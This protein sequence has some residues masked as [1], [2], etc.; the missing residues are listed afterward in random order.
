MK[1]IGGY[2]LSVALVFLLSY[3]ILLN[4]SSRKIVIEYP[5]NKTLF[6]PEFP[7]P[8]FFWKHKGTYLGEWRVRLLVNDSVVTDT[9]VREEKWRPESR[10]WE[11]IKRIAKNEHIVFQLS[12]PK[13]L[14]K[15][16]LTFSFSNDSVG[17]PILFRQLPIPFVLAEKILDSMNYVLVD[18]GYDGPPHVAMKSFPVCGNC[19][20]F[21]AGG[22][23]IGLDL[24]AGL[25]D[26]G[27]YFIAPITDTIVFDK[28]NYHSWTKIEQRRTFGMF[29]KLSPDGRYIVTTVK[30]R[31]ISKNFPFEPQHMAF[32]QLF[33]P[34][35]G[36]LAVYDRQTKVL[37]ELPGANLPEYVQSN[38]TWTP[39]GKYIV[40]CRAKALPYDNN[41]TL[42]INITDEALMEEFVQRK[43]KVKFDI[44]IIP[45]NDGKGGVAQPIKGASEN[46]KSNYF[47]A[48]SPDGKWLVFCQA[49]SFMLLQPDSR[50]YIVPLEGGKARPLECNLKLMNSWHAWSP[51]GKWLT[52]VS[53]GLSIYTD[54][55]LT[56]IDE[57]G[58]ASPPVLVERARK[59][60]RVV[61]YP[62]F[63]N[64]PASKKFDMIY[65]YVELV[66]IQK[67]LLDN[68]I[69]KARQLYFK[70][71]QQ[72]H[73]FMLNEDVEMLKKLL[74]Q[75]HLPQEKLWAET[76]KKK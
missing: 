53:K 62:E 42:Q 43:R 15:K 46:G 22:E 44:C 49:E 48:V 65:D 33:F 47:P 40:F 67:A 38:A 73:S 41:D 34:V 69:T 2:I 39:D 16:S 1:K 45:F 6:P 72:D 13:S 31:V 57:K 35:N 51:N 19:H 52:F 30:D 4:F 50:L 32:S 37:K 25:R 11:N 59:F 61:N 5:F 76:L 54:L 56:H 58:H 18:V 12:K 36:R 70:W 20:S 28:N 3:F 27:G 66:H 29:S 26:K 71:K 21:T 10:L 60:R 55:F 64:I 14:A 17:A 8:T 68:D 7:A 24:D 75:M 74:D 23:L 9:L 63:V